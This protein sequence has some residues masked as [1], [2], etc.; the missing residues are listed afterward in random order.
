MSEATSGTTLTSPG[1]RCAHPGSTL[2]SILRRD[3]QQKHHSL[4]HHPTPFCSQRTNRSRA[5]QRETILNNAFACSRRTRSRMSEGQSSHARSGCGANDSRFTSCTLTRPL[6]LFCSA[7]HDVWCGSRHT[8]SVLSAR[9]S[10]KRRTVHRLAA[11]ECGTFIGDN[12]LSIN[13]CLYQL[14]RPPSPRAPA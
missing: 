13:P 11:N 10:R 1:Y 7:S 4:V 12:Q 5:N 8:L 2:Q 9:C 6:S 3:R 14:Y